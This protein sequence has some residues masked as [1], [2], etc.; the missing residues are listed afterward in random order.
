MSKTSLLTLNGGSSSIKFALYSATGER[1][2][3]GKVERIGTPQA[4]LLYREDDRR[5]EQDLGSSDPI[6]ALLQ[7]IDRRVGWPALDAVSHR[8]VHG[9]HHTQ[10]ERV[11]PELIAYLHSIRAYDPDHLPMEIAL[12]D[13]LQQRYPHLPQVACFDTAFHHTLPRRASLLPLPRRFEAE[14]LRRYGFHGLSYQYLLEELTQAGEA[15]PRMILAHLGSGASLAAVRDGVSIDT[16][17]GFTPTGGLVMGT[18]PGDL[19]PGIAWYLMRSAQLTPAQFLHLTNQECGLLGVS[20]TSS[21]MRDLL[22]REAEDTRCAEAV[23]LFC[24]QTRKW[25][26]AFAAAL[27]GLDLLVFSGGIGENS[28]EARRRICAGLEFLGVELDPARNDAHAR[29]ISTA[30]ARVPVYV[31]PTD[32]ESVLARTAQRLLAATAR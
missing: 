16:S 25:I 11:T 10:P 20:E 6:D 7:F 32:E 5:E 29:R 8:V 27:E 4:R 19:D 3:G 28:A 13:R 24:Y 2:A 31:V 18:R 22:A 17:M 26:G 9:L 14:G 12:M 30:T 23:E 1:L 15:R 21:D